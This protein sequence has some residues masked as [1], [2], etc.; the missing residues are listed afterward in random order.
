MEMVVILN[1][2]LM[3]IEVKTVSYQRKDI[4]LLNLLIFI[5]GEDY[6]K[7]YLDF[8]RNEKKTIKYYD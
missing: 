2:K 1:M 5:T 6:T 3:I 8:I 4:V 7:Q